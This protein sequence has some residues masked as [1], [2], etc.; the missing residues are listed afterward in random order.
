[1]HYLT[2]NN[3]YC[4]AS[5]DEPSTSVIDSLLMSPHCFLFA[6]WEAQLDSPSFFLLL[7]AEKTNPRWYR[8]NL[9]EQERE[10][11][12]FSDLLDYSRKHIKFPPLTPIFMRFS[13]AVAIRLI[14]YRDFFLSK[15]CIP[16]MN[17]CWTSLSCKGINMINFF[18]NFHLIYFVWSPCYIDWMGLGKIWATVQEV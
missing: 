3:K 14:W 7:H 15:I 10:R 11:D 2:C 18:F 8:R 16:F 12:L 5:L 13:W 6:Y 4:H 17:Q 9:G 1:M